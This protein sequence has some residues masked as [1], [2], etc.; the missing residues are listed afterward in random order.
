MP[1]AMRKAFANTVD[2]LRRTA[3][4]SN[5]SSHEHLCPHCYEPIAELVPDCPKC[6]GTFK[7]PTRARLLS[8]LC[9]GLGDLYLGHQVLGWLQVA[10]AVLMWSIIVGSVFDEGQPGETS[11][12]LFVAA[13]TLGA[14]TIFFHGIDALVTGHTAKK[15][16]YPEKPGPATR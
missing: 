6:R 9:P 12:K 7:S 3:Q 1:G 11:E 5:V 14:F 10:G 8:F 13:F 4:I 2:G 15:G 16:L